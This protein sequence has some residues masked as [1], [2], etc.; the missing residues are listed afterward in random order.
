MLRKN[1]IA[2]ALGAMF[3]A[4]ATAQSFPAGPRQGP[5]R[6]P[7][8]GGIL[9]AIIPG[10]ECHGQPWPGDPAL[11]SQL[12]AAEAFA[13]QCFAQFQG[14]AMA[15]APL[16]PPSRMA[17]DKIQSLLRK[18][19]SRALAAEERYAEA[20]A[21]RAAHGFRHQEGQGGQ[22][23]P[24]GAILEGPG[25]SPRLDRPAPANPPAASPPAGLSGGNPLGAILGAVVASKMQGGGNSQGAAVIGAVI[26]SAIGSN[27][28]PGSQGDRQGFQAPAPAR[29]DH[30]AARSA[31]AERA[32]AE[33]AY[34]G[35]LAKALDACEYAASKGQDV[36]AFAQIGAMS[37]VP[38]AEPKSY[39][40]RADG[41][42]LL[43]P[44]AAPAGP[45][46]QGMPAP[47]VQIRAPG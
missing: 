37:T 41:R 10:P 36:S 31:N 40:S 25:Y 19:S 24:I 32:S 7:G 30:A 18:S 22:S 13:P 16:D 28:S 38:M 20:A 6:C 45:A 17:L 23:N 21:G 15:R 4:A 2:A 9:G 1:L 11:S 5:D 3:V 42:A 14:R 26:S 27:A 47:V 34:F 35:D 43:I 39:S 46:P 8:A 33:S 29:V 44:A 12:S